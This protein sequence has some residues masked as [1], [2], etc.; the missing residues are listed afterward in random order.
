MSVL[1]GIRAASAGRD[2]CFELDFAML[3]I[4]WRCLVGHVS[5]NHSGLLHDVTVHSYLPL[6]S[7]PNDILADITV[8]PWAKSDC[9]ST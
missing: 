1:R 6:C 3:L 4:L 2:Q 7:A 8:G 9:S 5:K